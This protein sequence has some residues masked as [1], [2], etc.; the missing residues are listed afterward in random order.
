MEAEL[1]L[2]NNADVW[3][4]IYSA[5]KNDLRY[6]SDVFVRLCSRYIELSSTSKILDYGFGT[7]ANL[8]HLAQL[9]FELS[10]VEI[11]DQAMQKTQARLDERQLSAELKVIA[12]GA[13]LPWP[14]EYF[15]VVISWQV[16]YYNDW[17]TWGRA[18]HELERVL[19]PGG[20]FIC[21]TAAP[22]DISQ[23]MADPIGDGLYQSRV[24]GQEGCIL[25]IPEEKQLL[26]CFPER[27]LELGELYCRIGDTV[28]R[29]WLV[30]YWKE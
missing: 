13:E 7:G 21:A 12:P 9:G 3:R 2:R 24:H 18:V 14:S 1:T 19:K 29:H 23:I 5:G 11:S 8:I 10:G 15:D 16:L 28:S 17:E 22:G 27:K 26:E 25:L 4:G 6:P 30:V 20:V